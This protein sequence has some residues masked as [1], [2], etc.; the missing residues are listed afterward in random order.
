MERWHPRRLARRRLAAE[1]PKPSTFDSVNAVLARELRDLLSAES[2]W[3]C[4][5]IPRFAQALNWP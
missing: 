2:S 1:R 5:E 3:L 4:R